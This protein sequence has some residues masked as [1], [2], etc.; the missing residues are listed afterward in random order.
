MFS[1]T[2]TIA[3]ILFT[4]CLALPHTIRP[5]PPS[6]FA[7][8]G[9]TPAD[10]FCGAPGDLPYSITSSPTFS[11][12]SFTGI[13]N[14]PDCASHCLSATSCTSFSY[15]QINASCALFTEPL[16]DMGFRRTSGAVFWWDKVCFERHGDWAG[17]A[18]ERTHSRKEHTRGPETKV[19]FEDAIEDVL[20]TAIV[21][22]PSE[23]HYARAKWAAEKAAEQEKLK[24]E[25]TEHQASLSRSSPG[26]GLLR[27]NDA[28]DYARKV[29]N[30]RRV[31]QVKLEQ[32]TEEAAEGKVSR[33]WSAVPRVVYDD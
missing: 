32:R 6:S 13:L 3:T 26:S 29:I 19:N 2:L 31:E 9:T 23:L 16:D 21:R 30:L 24:K 27:A 20:T 4:S 5:A 1:S 18:D 8:A 25:D 28:A 7:S 22:R 17:R 15:N 14:A 11:L 33:R 10:S 12:R